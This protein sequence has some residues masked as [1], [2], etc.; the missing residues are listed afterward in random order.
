MKTFGSTQEEHPRS[1]EMSR[2]RSRRDAVNSAAFLTISKSRP[3]QLL[4]LGNPDCRR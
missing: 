1:Q 3:A 4:Q 2:W